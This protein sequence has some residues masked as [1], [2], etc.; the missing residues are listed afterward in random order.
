MTKFS[1][2]DT[3]TAKPNASPKLRPGEIASIVG[4][5]KEGERRG[6]Y[7]KKFPKGVVYTIEFNDGSDV[8]AEEDD[9]ILLIKEDRKI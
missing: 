4:I 7:L 9:L 8:Q 3:V 6:G 1:W 2:N 5:S